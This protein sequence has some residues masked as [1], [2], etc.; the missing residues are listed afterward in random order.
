MY[1]R[2]VASGSILA[3]TQAH[4]RTALRLA[5]T[6]NEI[7]QPPAAPDARAGGFYS[8]RLAFPKVRLRIK[9]P[10]Q[11]PRISLPLVLIVVVEDHL[12]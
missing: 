5:R 4:A 3:A 7:N 2:C 8:Q 11:L 6:G 1:L 12:R 9:Q 10:R